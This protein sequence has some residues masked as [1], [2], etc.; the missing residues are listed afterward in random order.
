MDVPYNFFGVQFKDYFSN[1]YR[2]GLWWGIIAAIAIVLT[3]FS[4]WGDLLFSWFKRK[5]NIKDFGNSLP[6]HGGFLDRIDSFTVVVAVFTII[7]FVV[8]VFTAFYHHSVQTIFP[9][10]F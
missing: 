6:G 5:N 2:N 4:V 8:S 3:I 10:W 7:T 9:D 1:T